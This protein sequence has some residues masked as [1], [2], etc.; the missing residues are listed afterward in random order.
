MN[1]TGRLIILLT[2]LHHALTRENI[3]T[4]KRIRPLQVDET[5]ANKKSGCAPDCPIPQ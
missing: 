2:I 5:P 1:W 4:I 3:I